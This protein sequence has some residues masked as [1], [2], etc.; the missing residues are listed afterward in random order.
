MKNSIH[1]IYIHKKNKPI[2][3]TLKSGPGNPTNHCQSRLLYC[4]HHP[5]RPSPSASMD[6]FFFFQRRQLESASFSWPMETGLA[7]CPSIPDSR[8]RLA[9]SAKASAVIAMMGSF[10]MWSI[11]LLRIAWAAS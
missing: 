8:A 1:T 7:R 5:W 9:S 6:R 11:W 2:N 4:L 3:I 10:W